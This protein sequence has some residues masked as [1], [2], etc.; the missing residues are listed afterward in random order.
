MKKIFLLALAMGA[1]VLQGCS[2]TEE[3]HE[4]DTT[5]QT[6]QPQEI[7]RKVT[8]EASFYQEFGN[9][10]YPAFIYTMAGIRDNEGKAGAMDFN[11]KIT[12]NTDFDAKIKVMNSTFIE[13][14]TKY[15]SLKKGE[16]FID[17]TP[18]WRLDEFGKIKRA[19]QTHF[20]FEVMD[21]NNKILGGD[22]L[23]LAYRSINECVWGM[24]QNQEF[25]DL[26]ILF[27]AYVNEDSPMI[28]QFLNNALRFNQKNNAIN[29]FTYLSYGWVGYSYGKMYLLKQVTSIL[30]Y[31]HSLGMTYSS[32]TN[33]SNYSSQIV[34]QY[35]RT[36]NESMYLQ[37]ANCVDGSVLLASILEKIGIHCFLVVEPGHMY[38]AFS[39]DENMNGV[40]SPTDIS[41]LLFIE[42]TLIG[43]DLLQAVAGKQVK[44]ESKIFSI[45]QIRK[46]GVKPILIN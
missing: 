11:L 2:K 14:T 24:Y 22:D 26:S 43:S 5:S 35:V 20:T 36:I 38:L 30:S 13:E 17:I 25:K 39:T 12:S 9:T 23:Q 46:L 7:E 40:S 44:P 18:K 41:K 6:Q 29:S 16:N 33:T 8:V 21:Y 45:K 3:N 31:L 32:I 1:F 4:K 37:N 10:L 27:G 15:V 28:D 42:T 34:S 19:S